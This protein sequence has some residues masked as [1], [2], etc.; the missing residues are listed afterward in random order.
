VDLSGKRQ[1]WEG[2]VLLPMVD[3]TT[4]I[5]AYSKLINKVDKKN[6]ERNKLGIS[7]SFKYDKSSEYNFVSSFGKFICK[8]KEEEL[9]V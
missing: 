4:V 7:Y 1:E 2:T 9:I 5:Q 3:F 8:I 6:L